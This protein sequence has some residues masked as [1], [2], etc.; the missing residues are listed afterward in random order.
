MRLPSVRSAV[1]ARPDDL[2]LLVKTLSA[3]SD[4]E[5]SAAR[6][7]LTR[8]SGETINKALAD[9]S[10]SASPAVRAALIDVLATRR[11]RDVL[12]A[13]VA[14]TV[15]DNAQVRRAAMTA[16]GQIGLPEQIPQMLPG[17][18]KAA[19]GR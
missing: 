12:P 10:Q 3:K 8:I 5:Q 13:F 16:L 19:T 2:P 6:Q 15:D 17:V 7:C 1:W 4:V 11:A 9:A 14:A 18:L